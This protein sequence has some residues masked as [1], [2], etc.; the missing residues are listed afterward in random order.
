MKGQGTVYVIGC[1]F[2]DL[3]EESV[4]STRPLQVQWTHYP[5]PETVCYAYHNDTPIGPAEHTVDLTGKPGL[6]AFLVDSGGVQYNIWNLLRGTD[7]WDPLGMR[8]ALDARTEQEHLPVQLLLS[9]NAIEL[10][11][12]QRSRRI[13]VKANYFSGEICENPEL[14]YRI[15][16]AVREETAI[17]VT[18][19][20]CELTLC[21]EN[22]GV[23]VEKQRLLVH[24]ET[25]LTAM[26]EAT[27]P[28]T[29]RPA[30][31][32]EEEPAVVWQDGRFT[33]RYRLAAEGA[34]DASRIRWILE[35]NGE[36]S[37]VS[38]ASEIVSGEFSGVVNR[39]YCPGNE[40]VGAAVYVRIVPQTNCSV[41]GEA[42][43]LCACERLE[44][45]AI[46]DPDAIRTDFA[47]FPT[48]RQPQ[49]RPQYWTRDFYTPLEPLAEWRKWERELPGT[50]W[51]Y[52]SA[53]NGCVGMGLMPAIQG[54]KLFYTFAEKARKMRMELALDPAKTS[55]QGFGSAGQYMDVCVGFD[56]ETMTG[57]ALRI[58]RSP[59]ASNAVAVFPVVYRD[60][61]A[62]P[63]AERCYT[64]G[65]VTGC[66]IEM[67]LRDGRLRAH[68]W[69]EKELPAA[70]VS[71]YPAEITVE[72]MAMP[73]G[74]SV[75]LLHT[76]TCGAGGWHNTVMLHELRAHLI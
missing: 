16:G 74:G 47:D 52:R 17:R 37:V 13:A 44:A 10:G 36:R 4:G 30:P 38:S 27:V 56:A 64:A 55:G 20:G 73:A 34:E 11:E 40:A 29:T 63:S 53:G 68:L 59:E 42:V 45:G 3:R 65:F 61:I 7:G 50:P 41:P 49:I 43:E 70:V 14:T 66:H 48:E 15:V 18:E 21:G 51:V 67:E 46:T 12:E 75:G 26:A 9:Q 8:G 2:E 32:W 28:P 62:E 54:V 23:R 25:G 72:T 69:T 31:Q 58:L 57:P 19:Q 76:G 5:A 22:N 60:G 39:D 1:H 33:L 35:R 71:E 24:T 6:R